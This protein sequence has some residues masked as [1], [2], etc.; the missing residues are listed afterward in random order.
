[1]GEERASNMK[2]EFAKFVL[3]MKVIVGEVFQTKK[4][5]CGGFYAIGRT[6][7]ITI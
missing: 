2:T 6:G 4:I 7:R 5:S 1:M 3:K